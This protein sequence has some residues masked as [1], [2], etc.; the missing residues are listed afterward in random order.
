MR[1]QSRWN[2][3]IRSAVREFPRRTHMN[4]AVPGTFAGQVKEVLILADDDS[5]PLTGKPPDL[6]VRRLRKTGFDDMHTITIER[7]QETRRRRGKLI[8]D[9]KFHEVCRTT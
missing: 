5:I 7:D 6:N 8:V 2:S 4:P 3:A 1:G 9:E